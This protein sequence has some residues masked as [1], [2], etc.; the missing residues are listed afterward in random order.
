MICAIVFILNLL[1]IVNCYHRINY[2]KSSCTYIKKITFQHKH[3]HFISNKYKI[4]EFNSKVIELNEDSNEE[5]NNDNKYKDDVIN[6]LS[7]ILD[8]DDG[9]DIIEANL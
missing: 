9:I 5:V 1:V 3:V 4:K 6:V 7:N 8:P 2:P